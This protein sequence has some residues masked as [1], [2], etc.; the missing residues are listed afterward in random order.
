MLDARISF[1]RRTGVWKQLA[2]SRRSAGRIFLKPRPG[3]SPYVDRRRPRA[4][5]IVANVGLRF[6]PPSFRDNDIIASAALFSQPAAPVLAALLAACY[7]IIS[8]VVSK[9]HP[10]VI[11][12]RSSPMECR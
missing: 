4:A 8:S 7:V 12:S 11:S 2:S 5:T 1:M 10:P 9:L 6:M 3:R